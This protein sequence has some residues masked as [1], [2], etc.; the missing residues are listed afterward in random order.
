MPTNTTIAV[1]ATQVRSLD[2]GIFNIAGKPVLPAVPAA[3]RVVLFTA[4][5]AMRVT[6]AHLRV[7]ATL[8]ASAICKLQKNSGGA[9]TDMTASTT[10]ATAGVVS[11]AGL[12]PL[13]LAAGDSVEVLVSGGTSTAGAIEYDVAAQRA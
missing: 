11:G 5:H 3:D 1:P 12:V 2:T 10:A 9:Y 7:P 8:G 4:P 13:D 6:A